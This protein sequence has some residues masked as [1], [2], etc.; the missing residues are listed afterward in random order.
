NH[1]SE[2]SRCRARREKPGQSIQEFGAT[3]QAL[4][5]TEGVVDFDDL[6]VYTVQLFERYPEVAKAY[7]TRY[8]HLLLD[9]FQD[10]NAVQFGLVQSLAKH[11]KTVSVFADDDQAIFRFAGAD[12]E[13]IVRFTQKLKAKEYPLSINY[14]CRSEIVARANLLI[15]ADPSTSGRQ[16]TAK[17]EGG[18][19]TV[20]V[21]GTPE[22]EASGIVS[23]ISTLLG[24]GVE[25]EQ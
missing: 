8:S 9:E 14:R 6:L 3:Y 15:Q 5:Q 17:R 7:G 23:E 2:W 13:N 25:P 10:T 16:M 22:Q 18:T 19:V 11:A 1:G 12:S 21:Y 24:Q 4:K 20:R